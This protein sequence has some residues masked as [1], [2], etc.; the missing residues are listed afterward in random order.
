VGGTDDVR[1]QTT[2]WYGD[3]GAPVSAVQSLF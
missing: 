1:D 3:V 2:R